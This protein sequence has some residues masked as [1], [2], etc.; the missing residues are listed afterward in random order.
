MFIYLK[1]LILQCPLPWFKKLTNQGKVCQKS[2]DTY[3]TKASLTDLALN[4]HDTCSITICS[5]LLS[6]LSYGFPNVMC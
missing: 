3:N 4:D 2:K 6:P 5:S 1:Y